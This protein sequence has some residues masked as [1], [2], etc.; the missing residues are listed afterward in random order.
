[1]VFRSD[2]AEEMPACCFSLSNLFI[3]PPTFFFVGLKAGYR[4]DVLLAA[5]VL[6]A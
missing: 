1:V 5:L 6:Y 3:V 2:G 4:R